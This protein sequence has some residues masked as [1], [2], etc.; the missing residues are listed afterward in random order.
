MPFAYIDPEQLYEDAYALAEMIR[1]KELQLDLL[2]A[3]ARGGL[4]IAQVLSDALDLPV[5]SFTIQSYHGMQQEKAL[6]ITYG[7]TGD[8]TDKRLL[9]V[10]DLA[11]SGRTFAHAVT[12]LQDF[13]PAKIHTAA[14]YKK[15]SSIFTPDAFVREESAW[16]IFPH[17]VR[18]TLTTLTQQI[19]EAEAKQTLLTLGV[20]SEL[21]K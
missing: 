4:T 3:I 17:E 14:L 11:D 12:Y 19:G 18:E 6:H 13:H 8:L 10:D 9:V 5:A 1:A 20:E 21:V 7:L 16:L 15:P 2:V